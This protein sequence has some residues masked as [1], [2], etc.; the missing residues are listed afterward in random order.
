MPLDDLIDTIPDLLRHRVKLAPVSMA[1][2]EKGNSQSWTG[3]TWR[4]FD[5]AV[6]HLTQRLMST[7]L[8]HGDQVAILMPNA[9]EWEI[10]QHAVFRLGGVIIGLDLNDPAQRVDDIFN[11]C[12]IRA[13]IIDGAVRLDQIPH[14]HLEAIELILCCRREACSSEYAKVK[15]LEDIQASPQPIE[16]SPPEASA[17]ATIIFTSGTT[18]RPKALWYTHGQLVLAVRSIT[19]LFA[20]LPD[21]AH[22]ACWLPLANPFQR[23]I[24]L[25][26]I[27]ANWQC[28][29]VPDPTQIMSAVR[30]IE[31]HFFAG[32]PRFYEKLFQAIEG[33]IRQ[34]PSWQKVLPMWAV[35]V[36]KSVSGKIETKSSISWHLRWMH[37]VADTLVLEKIRRIMGRQLKYFISGSAPLSDELIKKSYA[38]GWPIYE[39]YGISENIAP[40][41]MNS[42]EAS[43]FGSVGRPLRENTIKIAD[44]GEIRVKS[45][46]IAINLK[47]DE[48]GGFHNTGDLG[49]IASDGYLYLQ[50]R[51]NDT[52]K[53]STGRK[54]IPQPIEEALSVLDGV[55]HCVAV[56]HK[57]KQVIA[58][59]NVP[60]EEWRHLSDLNGGEMGAR[61]FLR[62]KA[63]MACAHLPRYCRPTEVLIINDP[64]SPATGELTTNFKLR[65]NAVLSKYT[66]TI[67]RC[68][69]QIESES[70]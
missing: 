48:N 51:K 5:L 44:D 39:A 9:V 66:S 35:W 64:F 50:G 18:G 58:L 49:M 47:P 7:G 43:R 59:L 23:I 37:R 19:D 20:D 55:E 30:E 32:V 69:Q 52:F 45:A 53:L 67:N 62:N 22:T 38:F 26:A 6:E 56:G 70:N 8:G 21:Q 34:K 28:F 68:Y 65:R 25:C 2:L 41:A 13:L 42:P 60:P 15:I 40:M 1:L 63:Q 29:I 3:L 33:G 57:R 17:V 27:A 12:S 4:Q 10:T 36:G 16:P 31:P 11:Q 46:C 61:S 54:I 24:N 14:H